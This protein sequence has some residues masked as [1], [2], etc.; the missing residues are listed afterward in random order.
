MADNVSITAGSGTTIATDDCTTAGHTQIVKLA[1]STDGSATLIPAVAAD[2]LL[3]NLG[4]NN[5]VTLTSGTVT[6]LTQMNGAAISMNSGTRDAGTQRVTIATNDAVPV[7]FTGSTDAATQTTLASLLTSSQLIDDTVYADEGAFT[8][9]SSKIKAVGGYAVA[10]NAS[11]DATAAGTVGIGI[12]NR[13]RVPFTIGGHPNVVSASAFVADSDNGQTNAAIATVS[14]GSKIV[15]TRISVMASNANTANVACKI[16]FGASAVP[17]DALTVAAD[18]L[19]HH[20]GIPPGGGFT[21]GDGSG[22]LGVGAD[23]ADLR[24]TCGDPAGGSLSV[25]ASYYTIES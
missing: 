16:G 24:Y 1:I 5:D 4:T 17:A 12:M 23:G 3:V 15:V 6:S 22:M 25:T 9:A 18:I 8:L 13:H 14:A 21:I 10:H 11:P 7:T 19:A 20:P 2:G